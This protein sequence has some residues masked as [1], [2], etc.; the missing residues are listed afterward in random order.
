MW[1]VIFESTFSLQASLW[2]IASCS[3]SFILFCLPQTLASWFVFPFWHELILTRFGWAQQNSE[4]KGTWWCSPD[5]TSGNNE[6]F[7]MNEVVYFVLGCFCLVLPGFQNQSLKTR[8]FRL[9]F[10]RVGTGRPQAA[11]GDGSWDAPAG[12]DDWSAPTGTAWWG[13]GDTPKGTHFK[14]WRQRG[15]K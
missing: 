2:S 6:C 14:I 4:N 9:S 11:Q 7:D 8:Q 1:Q 15:V 10:L 12:G 5:L 3:Q 13:L